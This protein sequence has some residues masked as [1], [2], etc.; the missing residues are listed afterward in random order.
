[1]GTD[2]DDNL[3][4]STQLSSTGNVLL[5]GAYGDAKGPNQRPG[6]VR[7]YQYVESKDQWDQLGNEVAGL[8]NGDRFGFSTSMSADG[9]SK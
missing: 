2:L 1:L 7:A 5:V 4:S 3:G 8:A 6:H 9:E